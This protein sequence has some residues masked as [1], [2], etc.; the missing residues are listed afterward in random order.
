MCF[1]QSNRKIIQKSF[2]KGSGQI[3][4]SVIDH[5]INISKYNPLAGRSY[6][7]LPKKLYHPRKKLNNTQNIDD[8]EC[9]K[10]CYGFADHNPKRITKFYKDF[11]KRLDFKHI[12]FPVKVRNIQKIE[13]KNSIGLSIFCCENKEKHPMYVSNNFCEEK[14]VDLLLI[15]EAEKKEQYG[16]IKDFNIC[17]YDHSL[18]H[19]RKHFC[20]YFLHAFF[21]KEV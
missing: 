21:T 1:N 4:D 7:K 11:A 5:T 15:G 18:H 16:L 20:R 17:M 8:N 6:I 19:G 14:H 2:G 12:K 13:E 10:W 9:F 3:I